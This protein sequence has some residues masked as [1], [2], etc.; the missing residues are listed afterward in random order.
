MS[1]TRSTRLARRS[2]KRVERV[3]LFPVGGGTVGES[4]SASFSHPNTKKKISRGRSA[5]TDGSSWRRVPAAALRGFANGSSPRSINA[6][7][8]ALKAS[9]GM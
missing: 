9:R 8:Y 2:P 4:P 5:T 7:L 6:S 1:S 3:E